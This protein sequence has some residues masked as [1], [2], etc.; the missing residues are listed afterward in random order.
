MSQSLTAPP[1]IVGGSLSSGNGAGNGPFT[2]LSVV[3]Q[4]LI[5]G[6]ADLVGSGGVKT[7][8]ITSAAIT[9]AGPVQVGLSQT[10]PD[11][12]ANFAILKQIAAFC[13][14][15][16][17]SVSVDANLT[18]APT[19][20]S[21]QQAGQNE[22]V[23]QWAPVA[24]AA[25]L[26]IRQIQD[27]Q[28]IATSQ[29][30]SNF[31]NYASIEANAVHTLIADYAGS[32]YT[33]TANNLSVGDMEGGSSTAALSGWWNAYDAAALQ[34]GMPTFSYV[35]YDYA[36]DAPWINE[37][38]LPA[39]TSLIENMSSTAASMGMSLRI[40]L[41]GGETNATAN[42]L[43]Q[44]Q[45][46]YAATIAGLEA[47]GS[48]SVGSLLLQ[49]WY[50]L[51]L[52]VGMI[53]SPAS[54][55]NVAAEIRATYPL[56]LAGSITATGP[57]S[58]ATPDQVV[59]NTGTTQSIGLPS[60]AWSAADQSDGA[61]LAV[62]LIDQTGTLSAKASGTGS[63]SSSASNI[64]ILNGNSADL[65]AELA[66][67]TLFEGN[68]GADT[69]DIQIFNLAGR[70][71]DQQISI[72]AGTPGQSIAATAASSALQGWVASSS[73]LNSGTTVATGSVM[74][75]QTVT[76]SMP[77]QTGGTI[78]ASTSSGQSPFYN[79]VGVHEPL[80]EYGVQI[81]SA[82]ML[83]T[84]AGAVADINNGAVDYSVG[85]VY[86]NN[87]NVNNVSLNSLA[88]WL[89]NSFNA[90]AQLTPMAVQ[91]TTKLFDP[92][93]GKLNS[94]ISA[95]AP[96]PLTV[97]DQTGTHPDTFST[98]FNNG[99]TQVV[100][101]NNGTNPG[102]NA[103]WGSEF[104]SATLTYDGPGKL[105]EEFLQGGSADPWFTTDYVF[106]PASGKLW[107]EFQTIPPPPPGAG[108]LNYAGTN[109][110]YQTGFVTGSMF[111]TQFNTGNNPNW[112]YT[113]WGSSIS[114]ATE[115]WSDYFIMAAMSGFAT[116]LS[117]QYSGYVGQYQSQFLNA[118]Q[119]DLM[120]LPGTNIVDL[121]N[122]TTITLDSQPTTDTYSGVT[123]VNA[124]GSTG[125][126]TLTGL[127]AGHCTL[128][129]GDY[130]STI[131]GFGQDTI[132]AGSGTTDI[133]TGLGN[134]AIALTSANGVATLH[135]DRN[136]ISVV[137][138][139][140]I[141]LDGNA[142][143]V[144][145]SH[146]SVSLLIAGGSLE[147][148]GNNNNIEV[149]AGSTVT[150]SGSSDIIGLGA[151]ATLVQNSGNASASVSGSG[152]IVLM[153]SVGGTVTV[154]GSYDQV[155]GGTDATVSLDGFSNT[156]T[157]SA[158]STIFANG[159]SEAI[160]T[161]DAN[162][163]T[164]AGTA[165]VSVFGTGDF[166]NAATG[167]TIS[168]NG[169][170]DTLALS[171]GP[172]T[173]QGVASGA[174]L[175]E[176]TVASIVADIDMLQTWASEGFV[177]RISLV[178][179]A[180]P[181]LTMSASKI[182]A[183]TTALELIT[184]PLKIQATS[185][186]VANLA[187]IAGIASI[188]SV[189][190]QDSSNN[191]LGG[192]NLLE[193]T[194]AAGRLGSVALTDAA[195]PTF[196]FSESQLLQ[197]APVLDKISTP[198]TVSVLN[199]L[200]ADASSI[201]N[202]S[203]VTT[204]TVSDSAAH[205][206]DQIDALA[207]LAQAGS[208]QS[209]TLNAVNTPVLN[210]TDAQIAADGT[211]LARIV[212]PYIL[213]PSAAEASIAAK[214]PNVSGVA[215]TDTTAN[216][217]ANLTSLMGLAATGKLSAVH[218]TDTPTV[219]ITMAGTL[220]SA[221]ALAKV[222]A[223]E[224]TIPSGQIDLQSGL[225]LTLNLSGSAS[226]TIVG[227]AN[228]DVINLGS[229]NG[230][231][232][233]GSAQET[234]NGG[235]AVSSY[236]ATASTIG[237]TISGGSGYNVLLVSGGGSMQMGASITGIQKMYLNDLSVGGYNLTLNALA[238][239]TVQSGWG[240]NVVTVEAA[241][242]TVLGA[243]GH[244]TVRAT[245]ANAGAAVR[246]GIGGAT[247]EITTGGTVALNNADSNLNVLL[248]AA[249]TVILPSVGT[250]NIQGSAGNDVFTATAATLSSGQAIDGGG[251]VNSLSLQGSGTFYLGAPSQ[252]QNI[253]SI[254]VTGASAS[255]SQVVALRAGLDLSV[256]VQDTAWVTII[257][258]ANNDVINLGS[259]KA[260][261][262]LG[263]AGETVNGGTG[264]NLYHATASTIGATISGGSGFNVL[265]VSGGG[266]MVMGN[267]ITNIQ[268]M[269]LNDLSVGGYDL[270]LNAIAGLTV[271][272]GWGTNVVTVGAASQTILGAG[273][274]LTVRATAANAA[275]AVCGGIG[276]ATLDI[277]TG[278]T[279]VLNNADTNLVVHLD[280]ATNLT[281]GGM[282]FIT[283]SGSSAGHDAIT[284]GGS[285]QTLESIGGNDILTGS[286]SFGD[287]FA[288]TCAG[289]SGDTILGF[290]GSDVLDISDLAFSSLKPLNFGQSGSNILSLA[291]TTH[292][293]TLSLIGSYTSG[294]F[295]AVND[296]HGGTLIR[297]SHG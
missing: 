165:S 290:G 94:V 171:G 267:N 170:N 128:I 237:A 153:N 10:A 69:L 127:T 47:G 13:R 27:V 260:D 26:P 202:T 5:S 158:G 279:V 169:T 115:V 119:L 285:N 269:Y 25:G 144:S 95:L 219:G 147:V 105:T 106:D 133:F 137:T 204:I 180:N 143:I 216:I 38:A 132:V 247:L 188:Q 98:A 203:H 14:A 246:G 154:G 116:N 159:L 88:G 186:N 53:S 71:L 252:L 52:G 109:N 107:E 281:L 234:V 7:L 255:Q 31:Q 136:T 126:V 280:A 28:E 123:D 155:I 125:T 187:A 297:L 122:I 261:V 152:A 185:A 264:T 215:A 135:G 87:P 76:W 4:N 17:I 12:S 177:Q 214:L 129:G 61:R 39:Q 291:D 205:V 274:M 227:A 191:V 254:A 146:L 174:L 18:W 24:A 29:S 57:V 150:A 81:A 181:T 238:G 233:L 79:I 84:A 271:Q 235:T 164:S 258:A 178:G 1:V 245:A 42:Q 195:A 45:E 51:P 60:L 30:P 268:E 67:V 184:T 49:S 32:S 243:G 220:L 193:Q 120:F 250:I 8:N 66:S 43:A 265:L 64:L 72:L 33:M 48:I 35:T 82:A 229:A 189:A 200:A 22:L 151:A 108:S 3:L 15:N 80:A 239:L 208:L 166:I 73:F 99:G 100:E 142:N 209:I 16:N 157:V 160:Y 168:V 70:V 92:T 249:A 138:G 68:A 244:V 262:W 218:F 112:N 287:T 236:H 156:A 272:S 96:D 211:A 179:A 293:V 103:S 104:T 163:L 161:S 232:W 224:A 111:I 44:Q 278:G 113:D 93:T 148:F 270:T 20:Q 242:Q 2:S 6:A 277:T 83:G 251:G 65:A 117:Q 240:T 114:S 90:A 172:I 286:S 118:N 40:A 63:V 198:Y 97:V 101:Y 273:G 74:T 59:L 294:S 194:A 162:I 46:Q 276:G 11:A 110:P 37:L 19:W 228:A 139:G 55:L 284:A 131:I 149:A 217:S 199:A 222:Q 221:D 34:I 77:S 288:G 134:S 223:V 85:Q 213:D 36:P 89:P 266:T 58:L 207:G 176:D 253:A 9:S 23:T 124:S 86:A 167:S 141:T 62:V 197:A 21:G 201:A 56:Y 102:W 50:V 256:S 275:A 212:T 259:G 241:S 196:T 231:V 190:V 292:G 248:D 295:A 226:S 173:L 210:L 289:L 91:S 230:D 182:V 78:G 121:N 296:G 145:G 257:G 283:A 41:Q 140:T 183:D 206:A 282:S 130:Q 75:S 54:P 175:V 192:L 263:S 225:N